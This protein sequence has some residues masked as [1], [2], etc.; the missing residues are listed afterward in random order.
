[1]I[2]INHFSEN[3]LLKATKSLP[4]RLRKGAVPTIFNS[5]ESKDS[6]G[7]KVSRSDDV[8]D[9]T[10]ITE[11]VLSENNESLHGLHSHMNCE[12]KNPIKC[13]N[14]SCEFMRIKYEDLRD[15]HFRDEVNHQVT[16]SKMSNEIDRLKSIIQNQTNKI[17]SL[18]HQVTR[19][20][21]SKNVLSLLL[22]DLKHQKLL[23]DEAS[24]ALQV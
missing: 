22:K 15:E 6:T 11:T 8:A 18:S 16:V 3:D 9:V 17:N 24:N 20:K 21:E 14:E 10:E 19:A 23:N 13:T 7:S 2:C 12:N 1:M 4:V 5:I